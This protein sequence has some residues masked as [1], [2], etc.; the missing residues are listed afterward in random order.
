METNQRFNLELLCTTDA[1]SS[2]LDEHRRLHDE[3]YT[4]IRPTFQPDA[5]V[6]IAV[7]DWKEQV[8]T[9]SHAAGINVVDF[10]SFIRALEERRA[11]F[12][13]LGALA[14]DHAVQTPYTERLSS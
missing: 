11:A 7:P 14:T 6:N 10:A 9:L 2:T 13:E 8:D 4:Q 1:A 5:V 12:K 3:G